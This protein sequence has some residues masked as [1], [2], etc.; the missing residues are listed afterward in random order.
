M[1]LHQGIWRKCIF[2]RAF[3]NLAWWCEVENLSAAFSSCWSICMTVRKFRMVMRNHFSHC[4]YVLQ[5]TSFLFHFAWLC[6]N[7]AWS[8]EIE[9][10][11]FSTPF[12][13][14]SHFFIFN[15]PLPPSIQLQIPIQTDCIASFIMHLDHHQLYF[16]SSIWFISFVT[17][18]SKLYL[19]MTP[20]LY[21]TC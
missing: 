17:N 20:K 12:C 6:E 7:F 5:P 11:V 9:K 14:F 3:S 13:N 8:C 19:E 21:K 2:A 1:L 16:F 10:H 15:P 4:P 18:L